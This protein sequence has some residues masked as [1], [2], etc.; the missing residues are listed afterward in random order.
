MNARSLLVLLFLFTTSALGQSTITTIAGGADPYN[1]GP[2]V[3]MF[4]GNTNSVI[5]DGAGGFYFSVGYDRHSVY[6]VTADGTVTTIAGN[7][8]SGFSGDG[9]PATSARLNEPHGLALD[10]GGNLFIADRDNHRIRKITPAGIISTVAG[11]GTSGYSGDNGPATA[12]RFKGPAG[13]TL[14]GSSNLLVSDSADN[15]IRRITPTGTITTVVGTGTQ[16]F[17]GD[18]GSAT[19]AQISNPGGIAFSGTGDL[20]IADSGNHRIR[21]VSPGG[22]ITTVAGTGTFG[23]FGD[24]GLA[25]NARLATP[26]DVKVDGGGNLLIADTNNNRI[27]RVSPTGIITTL[28]GAVGGFSG[29]NGPAVSAS[30]SGP[31]GVAI[32]TA[33]N[34][35]IADRNNSRIRRVTPGGIITTVAGIFGSGFNGD[36]LTATAALLNSPGGIL[37]DS[38]GNLLIADRDNHRIRKVTATGIISTLAGTG[39]PGVSGDGG[40]ATSALLD[41]PLGLAK[42]PA[43]NVYITDCSARIRKIDAAGFISSVTPATWAFCSYYYYYYYDEATGGELAV[44]ASGNL[45]VADTF[46]YRIRKVTPA[47][48]ISV[49]A[50]TG[51]YGFSGDGGPATSAALANPRGVALDAAENIYFVDSFNNRIRKITPAGIISTVAGDGTYG[52]GGDGGPATAAKFSSPTGIAIDAAGN[53]YIADS[54]NNRIRKVTADGLI[55]TV[56]GDGFYGLSGDGGPPTSARLAYP[57]GV[58]V[59]AGGN[60]YI[61][62]S[63]NHRIRKVHFALTIP[64]LVGVE[65]PL[66]APGTSVDVT[67]IGSSFTDPMTINAGAGVTVSNVKVMSDSVASATFAIAANATI[68]ARNVNVTTNLGTSGNV[69]FNVEL[70]F[71]DLLISGSGFTSTAVGFDAT[72]ALHIL[73]KGIAATSGPITV[74]D[75]LPAGLSFVSGTGT[76]WSCSSSGQIVDCN[77]PQPL[78]PDASTTLNLKFTAN[79][80]GANNHTP[81]VTVSGDLVPSNNTTTITTNVVN[82]FFNL[83]FIPITPAPASQ[84]TVLLT[85][86]TA[87]SHEITG[88]LILIF[89]PDAVHPADDPAI[90]FSSGGREVTFTIPANTSQA[91]FGSDA[92]S[93]IAFQT[94]TVAG[95]LRF[96]VTL[97][98]GTNPNVSSNVRTISRRAPTIHSARA[99]GGSPNTVNLSIN[100]SSTPREV[101]QLTLSFAT[102]TKINVSCGTTPNCTASGSTFTLDVKQQFD[103]WYATDTLFGSTS[104]L[105][106]PLTLDGSLRGSIGITLRNAQGNSNSTSVPL[107]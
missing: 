39:S 17:L 31:F 54:G 98:S 100:L 32:D 55:K 36:N 29:D 61:A 83:Q 22:T 74:T 70:P 94:G 96:N 99:Q 82:P 57:T 89:T 21:K 30:L 75:E 48:V 73:N 56:A 53:L 104:T 7:G 20:L 46:N 43:G 103:A 79:T 26:A 3:A 34:I 91:R 38:T 27:R 72:V 4:F 67:L 2:A 77:N 18:Q 1:G 51:S 93:S 28:A 90:Q 52:F 78:A 19:S 47:G 24:N 68:G 41:S 13:L 9:G 81:V 42:D 76:D 12:A 11:T 35:L 25:I 63:N 106:V 65:L 16:G 84:G 86:G 107:P 59:D 105:T 45:I 71:P 49:V 40:P 60:L 8:Q 101:T 62:D 92:R 23:F 85:M 64:T 95:S 14:D 50:G 102:N 6:R 58:A 80:T 37:L 69:T 33:G 15:R 97:Q 5:S 44:D 66:G 88:K 10:G 87:L